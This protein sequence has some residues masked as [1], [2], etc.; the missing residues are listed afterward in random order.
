MLARTASGIV[1]RI[2]TTTGGTMSQTLT[3][4]DVSHY[5]QRLT[6]LSTLP[7]WQ[8][9][10]FTTPAGPE[11]G[12]V[13]AWRDIHP[14]LARTRDILD[15]AAMVSQRRALIL[16]NPGLDMPATTPTIT[17]AYQ[18]LFP[19]ESAPVHAHSMSALRFGL[20]GHGAQMIIDG[21][22]VPM[23]PG[24]L[25]LTPGWSWHGHV[26]PG[27]DE[28]VA[29]MDG[30][31][32]PLVAGLRANFF[33]DDPYEADPLPVRDTAGT[34]PAAAGLAPAG[35]RAGRHSPVRRYPWHEAYP[36]LHR[37]MARA[38]GDDPVSRLEYR[39]PV[40]GGPAL[41]TLSCLLELLPAG[42]RSRP[43][44]ETASSVLVVALGTGTLVCGRQSFDLL[45]CDVAA[46]PAWMWHQVTAT[47]QELVLLRVTDRPV[48]EAFGLYRSE[49][50]PGI[51]P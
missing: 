46:I 21:D 20:T 41:A 31:D 29:W 10:D 28:P 22:R 47:N 38:H 6:D 9:P 12:H 40:T 35:E 25:I 5:Y 19:G 8:L 17:A 11:Q 48:H 34:A 44:R 27:G 45:P 37:M 50:A 33:R 14:E 39:N 49:T 43:R 4:A 23:E 26:H 24:D 3:P 1:I 13:W 32:V 18:M 15:D 36:A 51:A 2:G 16:R 30:L 7:F 42:A